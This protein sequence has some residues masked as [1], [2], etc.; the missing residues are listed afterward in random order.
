MKTRIL[1]TVKVALVVISATSVKAQDY[2]FSQFDAMVPAYQ[3]GK[4]GMF[5]DYKYR[6]TTQFRNQWRP[7]A[8]KPFSTFGLSYDMPINERWGVGGYLQNFDGARV[9]NSFN[10]VGSAAYKITDPGQKEHLLTT[11]LQL[12]GV[13]HNINNLDLLFENQYDNGKLNPTLPSQEA[14]VKFNKLSPEINMGVYYE[15]TDDAEKNYFPYAGFTVFH[16]TSPKVGVLDVADGEARV[17]RRWLF[18]GGCKVDVNEELDLDVKAL[19][20]F[21][22]RS[23]ELLFGAGGSY[24]LAEAK[25]D[26]LAGV[27]YRNQ[28][29]VIVNLGVTYEE[30][31][32]GLNYDITTSALREYNNSFG[33]L[34]F[35]LTYWPRK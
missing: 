7:L 35:S 6:A 20:Q 23:T 5:D 27:Y 31:T 34:E 33:A 18:N 21:Q 28:D 24:H 12:G 15:W 11:G 13:Y 25:T 19:Y 3:P 2:H 26:I 17:P 10:I 9:Y 14:F 1:N 32:F 22:G 29:A 4:T 30:L 16:L 8:T